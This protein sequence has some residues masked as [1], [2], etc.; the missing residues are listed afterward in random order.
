MGGV[1]WCV[2]GEM[3]EGGSVYVV[4]WGG[5]SSVNDTSYYSKRK[6]KQIDDNLKLF[7]VKLKL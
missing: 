1:K 5:E 6:P 2:C 3:R 7:Q 4:K